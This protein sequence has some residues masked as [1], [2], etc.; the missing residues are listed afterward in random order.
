M[1]H[2]GATL[3]RPV[4]PSYGLLLARCERNGTGTTAVGIGGGHLPELSR[5]PRTDSLRMSFETDVIADFR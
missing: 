4:A 1:I 3:A 2:S 5:S